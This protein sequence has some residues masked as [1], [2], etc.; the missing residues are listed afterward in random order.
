M[1]FVNM[2]ECVDELYLYFFSNGL[3]VVKIYGGI[4]FCECKCI[5]N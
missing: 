2:K 1:I 3:K 5:M 4:V